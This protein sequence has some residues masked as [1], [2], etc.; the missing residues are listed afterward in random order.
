MTGTG[1]QKM[2]IS[3]RILSANVVSLRINQSV[4]GDLELKTRM[5]QKTQ[6]QQQQT[7]PVLN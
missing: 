3:W 6:Q 2:F 4:V 1:R 5:L 7:F